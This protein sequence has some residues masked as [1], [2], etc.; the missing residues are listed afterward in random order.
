MKTW[1][2]N[3][4]STGRRRHAVHSEASEKLS[5]PKIAGRWRTPAGRATPAASPRRGRTTISPPAAA[6]AVNRSRL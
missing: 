3:T 5:L 4:T 6:S 2:Q 1:P